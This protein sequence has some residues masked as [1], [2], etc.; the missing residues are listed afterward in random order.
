MNRLR[1]RIRR[2]DFLA[3]S[4]ALLL[5]PLAN[6][7]NAPTAAKV[8]GILSPNPAPTPEQ[9]AQSAKSP[10]PVLR[11]LKE[12]GWSVGE[13][14]R[15]ETV[16]AEGRE[17]RLPELARALV[18]K[19]VDVIWALGPEAASVGWLESCPIARGNSGS[20]VLD[21]DEHIRA[22]V[23]GGTAASA[24]AVTSAPGD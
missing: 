7:Q 23:H 13:N 2:R 15:F 19:R 16:Y 22:I 6:A 9:L 18:K 14:L 24:Y 11:R 1:N 20:P 3:A 21:S 17:E 5:A 8:L 4:G 10:G 12:L